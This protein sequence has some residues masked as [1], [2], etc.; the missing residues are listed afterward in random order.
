MKIKK[1][2]IHNIASIVDATIDFMA[3]PLASADLFLISGKT[4]AGKTTILDAICLALYNKAPRVSNAS[5]GAQ[6]I[7]KDMLVASDPRHFMRQNTGEAYVKLSFI[8]NDGNEYLAE[9]SVRRGKKAKL[10]TAIS[11]QVWSIYDQN[12][13]V[14]ISV[15]NSR[16]HKEVEDFVKKIVGLDYEQFCR[17]T[18]LAQ[19]EFTEFLKS[20]EKAKTEILEKISN[21]EKFRR[22]GK[23]IYNKTKAVREAFECEEKNHAQINQLP[24]EERVALE[25]EK[26]ANEVSVK[27]KD[28]M[29]KNT[30][31]KIDWLQNQT[32]YSKALENAKVGLV[33]AE[34]A[35]L[36]EEFIGKEKQVREW[37]AT[38]EVRANRV[39]AQKQLAIKEKATTTIAALKEVFDNAMH[40]EAFE[41]EQ[42][43]AKEADYV[44]LNNLIQAEKSNTSVYEKEQT[45]AEKIKNFVQSCN[46]C[47]AKKV[48]KDRLV[49]TEIPAANLKLAA[50]SKVL[51]EASTE[52]ENA[53]RS[54]N[55]CKKHLEECNLP[56]KRS[57]KEL[58]DKVKTQKERIAE[59]V[60]AI[61]N[62]Q[63]LIAENS[64]QMNQCKNTLAVEEDALIR[65]QQ[66]HAR[67]LQSVN[68]FAKRIR[69]SLREQLGKE[70]CICP[71]CGQK[72]ASLPFDEGALEA[73][74]QK[75]DAE[76]KTQTQKRD[77]AK[78]ALDQLT[79]TV[80]TATGALSTLLKERE[81]LYHTLITM[82]GGEESLIESSISEMDS[83]I[84]ELSKAIANSEQIEKQREVAQIVYTQ[85]LKENATAEKQ[86]Q[87]VEGVVKRL[88]DKLSAIESDIDKIQKTIKDV[89]AS[90]DTMLEGS[91]GWQYNWKENTNEFIADL[92]AKTTAYNANVKQMSDLES[93]IK[94][95]NNELN[96]IQA[97][98]S[99]V[100]QLK[101]DWM[102]TIAFAPKA[103]SKLHDMWV[104]LNS[105]LQ[106]QLEMC[107]HAEGEYNHLCTLVEAFLNTNAEYT[108]ASIDELSTISQYRINQNQEFVDKIRTD[109]VTA[110]S[111]LNDAEKH[112]TENLS[113][114]PKDITEGDTEEVL[115]S[116]LDGTNLERDELNIRLGE[117]QKILAEDDEK[118]KQKS[119]TTRLEKLR[120]EYE[121][122][123]VFHD[124][125]GD[126][127]GSKF[128]TIAQGF[129]LESLLDAA[130]HHL[131]NMAPRYNLQI[132]PGT[133]H[134]K[135]EDQY[136][137]YAARSTNT[138][139]GGESF[140]V[141]LSLA[142]ALADFG[143]HLGVS[144]LFIDEGFGT[145]SGDELANAI[146]TLKSLH[147]K[148]GR[149][150]GIISH[151]EE[152]REN[153]PVQ[154]QVKSKVGTSES[155]I[156]I[157]S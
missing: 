33:K 4:G 106:T 30:Q 58:L 119:D 28:A 60:I 64:D 151:R 132:V 102:G 40:G 109:Y 115:Q 26:T 155:V 39:E 21:T 98:K 138:L 135:L 27:E 105:N 121:K 141:S 12:G 118:I 15:D 46:D 130:N 51:A 154:I 122:W 76:V 62:T 146:A 65:L 45:I 77:D 8:G 81:N 48:E 91:I 99:A 17:T 140:L 29:A 101:P 59:K 36:S 74:Y 124:L 70:D 5:G 120:A 127:E 104:Q 152:I 13:N 136:N 47:T 32:I 72:V 88:N 31:S 112:V 79:S 134:L 24:V 108:V 6:K 110:K 41:K 61:E 55:A 25:A 3:D 66:E 80:N 84:V 42:L 38:I 113:K 75:I 93:K 92:K 50:S 63:K 103:Q 10:E 156:E 73:V 19:G 16:K 53:E 107:R 49:N 100:L 78:K 145:L 123:K 86:K 7:D 14:C 153:I 94:N 54:L 131:E 11:N 18:L 67:R 147:S 52:L 68:E 34:G 128:S 56:A 117:I 83:M 1:L 126:S 43:A 143:Q 133:L 157:C 116:I 20:D 44:N 22:I 111:K 2:D 137:G 95:T 149:Q 96:R 69:A 148:V 87:E 71:A 37:N 142:L 150:V 89:T 85:K 35:V 125:F 90:I 97:I 129:V 139:S 114:K 23:A 82:C 9:W 57:R 144:T